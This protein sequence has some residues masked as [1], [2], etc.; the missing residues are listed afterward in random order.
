MEGCGRDKGKEER[1]EGLA[2]GGMERSK[3]G[4]IERNMEGGKM[5]KRK[6]I[7]ESE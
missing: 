2:E 5:E 1:R 7:L 3:K 6:R 4:G